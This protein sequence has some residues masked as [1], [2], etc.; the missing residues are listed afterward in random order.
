ML[1]G[2]INSV[3]QKWCLLQLS[4]TAS[5]TI[6][7]Q[8]FLYCFIRNFRELIPCNQFP[9]ILCREANTEGKDRHCCNCGHGRVLCSRSSYWTNES[10]Y[11]SLD[12]H[13]AALAAELKNWMAKASLCLARWSLQAA[14][15]L[16]WLEHG[17][18]PQETLW[19]KALLGDMPYGPRHEQKACTGK[20]QVQ[21]H[22]CREIR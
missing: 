14:P 9:L 3:M 2:C 12:I 17:I 7:L 13:V 4:G 16:Q 10:K 8:G 5:A 6:S 18:R 1:M 20:E 19:P 15:W 11:I 22:R 21:Q